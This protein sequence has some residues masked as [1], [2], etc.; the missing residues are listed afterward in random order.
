MNHKLESTAGRNI[1]NLRYEDD[2]TL[3]AESKEE[4]KSLLM[5]MKEESEKA[6]LKFNIQKPRIMGTSTI[7]SWQIVE[8]KSGNNGRF[9][10][11]FGLQNPV[12]SDSSC[13]IK[14]RAPWK[15]SCDKTRHHIKNQR[16][17]FA[18]KGPYSQSYGFSNS[19]VS[20]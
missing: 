8:G 4:L 9:Y 11:F 18:S 5:R 2:T 7:T 20:M 15:K 17:H 16:H 13:K 12:D 6:D 10:F 1:N 19:H 14:T 3:M